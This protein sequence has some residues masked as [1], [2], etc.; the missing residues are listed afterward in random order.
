MAKQR[1]ED[2]FAH[3]TMTFGEHLEE[4]RGALFKALIVLVLGFVVGLLVGERVVATIRAPLEKALGRYFS[5]ETIKEYIEWS[6]ERTSNQLP[7]PYTNGEVASMVNDQGM[8]YDLVEVDPRQL[9]QEWERG[10]P[11]QPTEQSKSY[12]G[13]LRDKDKV[14]T[15][16]AAEAD[17]LGSLKEQDEIK[18]ENTFQRKQLIP[19]ITWHVKTDDSR[20]RAQATGATEAFM[21]Y[22]KASLVVGVVLASPAMFYFIWSFVAAG[23]YPHEKSYVNTFLPFSIGLFLLGASTA[24]TFVFEPVLDYLF[25]FNSFLNVDPDPRINE[26]LS[27]VL[28]LPL[29]FGVAFQ[30]PLVML[31]LN[32]I[33]V[34]SVAQYLEKWR[35][36]ILVITVL[37]AVLT[38]A[39]PYSI[40]LLA[41]PLIVL[42]FTGVLVCKIWPGSKG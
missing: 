16:E 7:L 36:A 38:P 17:R 13:L 1:D 12:P 42:Y 32:R 9:V 11:S 24:Y 26:W 28:I 34:F 15:A 37:S 6:A 40:F 21:I 23:L 29:G 25:W 2:L 18:P 14:P 10:N 39:D 31:F 22:I 27:F 41:I 8:L 5:R 19:I 4:L 20:L 30:L 35:I 33:G 3:S